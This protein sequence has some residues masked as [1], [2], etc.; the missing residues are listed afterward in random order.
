M[1]VDRPA[2]AGRLQ[3]KELTAKY[4][5]NE[6]S[7]GVGHRPQQQKRR[8]TKEML[9][10]DLL[11]KGGKAIGNSKTKSRN[12]PMLNIFLQPR[13]LTDYMDEVGREFQTTFLITRH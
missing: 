13:L 7:Q 10:C 9:D 2:G 1:R 8:D 3:Q 4:A 11:S 5:K 12:V 6:G